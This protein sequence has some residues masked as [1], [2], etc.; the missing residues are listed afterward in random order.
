MR[1]GSLLFRRAIPCWSVRRQACAPRAWTLSTCTARTLPPRNVDSLQEIK[2]PRCTHDRGPDMNSHEPCT[3]PGSAAGCGG[4]ALGRQGQ[5]RAGRCRGRAAAQA[6]QVGGQGCAAGRGAGRPRQGCRGCRCATL[7]TRL[8]RCLPCC[9]ACA[10][11]ACMMTCLP[12]RGA[13]PRAVRSRHATRRKHCCP[14][15]AQCCETGE[16]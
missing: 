5:R 6:P 9:R 1:P 4:P 16:R 15:Y 2:K 12:R 3:V 10:H 13:V 7:K 8:S 11:G 14:R